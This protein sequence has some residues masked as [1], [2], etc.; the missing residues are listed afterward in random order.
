MEIVG[1]KNKK[2]FLSDKKVKVSHKRL[3]WP[4]VFRVGRAPDFLDVRHY[5][6]GRSSA[7]RTWPPLP[8]EKPMVLIIRGGDDPRAHGS[9]GSYENKSHGHHRESIPRPSD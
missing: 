9:I 5:K 8:Q 2:F 3:R 1:V 6:C 7:V 4:K